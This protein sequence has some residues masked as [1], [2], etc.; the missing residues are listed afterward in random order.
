MEST[1]ALQ[2][3]TTEDAV[4]RGSA[5]TA[6][7]LESEVVGLFDRFQRRMLAYLITCGLPF[8]DAEDI[9]QETFLS[10]FRHLEL[11]RSRANL[12]GWIFRVAHNLALK[13]HRSSQMFRVEHDPDRILAAQ[14][15]PDA[16]PEDHVA[17]R[18]M[19]R[20]LRAVFEA[21]PAQDQRCLHLRAEGLRY[22]D[23]A[24]VLGISLGSVSTSL[25]RS[26]ARMTRATRNETS[27]ARRSE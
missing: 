19:H 14:F 1:E 6:V 26:L 2:I 21:L 5:A 13:R 15:A 23:I 27:D 25:S 17:F 22:R 4:R 20:Q 10:L 12:T 24:D 8:H 9:V 7:E 3:L 11:G 16:D 18:Q